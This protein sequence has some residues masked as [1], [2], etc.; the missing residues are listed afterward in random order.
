MLFFALVTGILCGLMGAIFRQT[1]DWIGEFRVFLSGFL[2]GFGLFEQV[3]SVFLTMLFV[4]IA[5]YLVRR[6]APEA[7]GSGIHEIEGALD[8]VR[9]MRWKRVLPVKFLASLFSLGSG[10]L[11]GREGP[12]IQ[13]G[14]NI[15]KM[16][17]DVFHQPDEE[18]NPLVST[19]AGAGLASAFN[20]PLSGIIFV[21]EEMNGHFKFNFFSV[22]AIM[23][24][25]GISDIVVRLL[26]GSESIIHMKVFT[27]DD[28]TLLI[29]F[30]LLGFIFGII[31]AFYNSLLLKVVDVFKRME[32]STILI[33]I[34]FGGLISVIGLYS[35]DMTGAG[36]QTIF[37]VLGNSISLQFLILLFLVRFFF[38]IL[39]YGS[40]APGGIFAPLLTLGVIMGMIFGISINDLFPGSVT[41]PGIFAV[42]GMAAIFAST[43]RAPLTGLALSVEMTSNFELI[44]PLIITV[45]VASVTTAMLGNEPVYTSLLKRT[46]ENS[47]IDPVARSD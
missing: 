31:G 4:F 10:L 21:I 11:L 28:E 12:T 9:P 46:L 15:G 40:G 5:V 34:V 22:A 37:N 18:N 42:A 20:A 38:S 13:L 16:V 32:L 44:L 24:G 36:Y 26:V 39:S 29:Y 3:I 47:K 43:V 25:V 27:F 41:D 30:A 6:F 1:L 33:A 17:K 7:S 45:A 23:I 14:A 2:S 19:G 35:P 8:E